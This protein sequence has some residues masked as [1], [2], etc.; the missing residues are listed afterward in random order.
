[1]GKGCEEAFH[2]KENAKGFSTFEKDSQPQSI[3]VGMKRDLLNFHL[4]DWQK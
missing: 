1:M 3:P 4:A 2:R